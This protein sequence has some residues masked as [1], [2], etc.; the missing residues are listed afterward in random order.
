M[1]GGW[2][3]S[4]NI[5][6]QETNTSHLRKGTSSSK[7]PCSRGYVSFLEGIILQVSRGMTPV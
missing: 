3:I 7:V 1:G 2:L 4:H 5:I 6:F